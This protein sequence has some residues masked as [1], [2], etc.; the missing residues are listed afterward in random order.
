MCCGCHLLSYEAVQRR[1]WVTASI[2]IN[3]QTEVETV[4]GEPPT[5][6]EAGLRE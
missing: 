1:A 3:S 6:S 5:A 2:S 4:L